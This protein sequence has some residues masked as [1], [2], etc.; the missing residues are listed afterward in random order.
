[1]R[2]IVHRRLVFIP[3]QNPPPNRLYCL[4]NSFF[5]QDK[6]ISSLGENI[7]GILPLPLNSTIFISFWQRS[8]LIYLFMH[9]LWYITSC[10][11]TSP[12]PFKNMS[13]MWISSL[14]KFAAFR[15]L[16]ATSEDWI[17]N[18]FV[19]PW[20]LTRLQMTHGLSLGSGDVLDLFGRVTRD[21]ND[22]ERSGSSDFRFFVPTSC[23]A[24]F[25][26]YVV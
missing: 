26:L 17:W 13:V 8:L 4:A 19:S 25:F 5:L 22:E 21:V 3:S 2:S 11:H 15:N 10:A 12:V 7:S 23:L 9:L 18:L 16:S 1:M 6:S 20:H 14:L 24:P